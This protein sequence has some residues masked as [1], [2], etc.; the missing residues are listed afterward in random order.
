VTLKVNTRL[1]R[2]HSGLAVTPDVRKA[3]QVFMRNHRRMIDTL[4]HFS[5]IVFIVDKHT[6]SFYLECTKLKLEKNK[7]EQNWIRLNC[8]KVGNQLYST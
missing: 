4:V 5:M 6:K 1:A 2:T 7:T 3:Y 8:L